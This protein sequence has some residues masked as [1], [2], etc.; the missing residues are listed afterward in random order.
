LNDR[1]PLGVA[2]RRERMMHLR[3]GELA[4]TAGLRDPHSSTGVL[5]NVV[6]RRDQRRDIG[7]DQARQRTR[8]EPRRP[9]LREAI[10]PGAAVAEGDGDGGI[11]LPGLNERWQLD[12]RSAVRRY[13]NDVAVL[14]AQLLRGTR[15]QR[16]VIVPGD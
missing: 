12:R 10:R 2:T 15:R 3:R 11:V 7:A 14:D 16:G 6:R 5:A 4:P 9:D 8:F 1:P 13:S